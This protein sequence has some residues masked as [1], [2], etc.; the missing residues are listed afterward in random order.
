MSNETPVT[1]A[2]CIEHW[3]NEIKS[4]G[5]FDDLRQVMVATL[6]HLRA[7]A[8]KADVGVME[9][10]AAEALARPPVGV[11]DAIESG[12]RF[13]DECPLGETVSAAPG[14]AKC[15]TC[16]GAGRVMAN[17]F[18]ADR[19][20]VRAPKCTETISCP[21]CAP[22]PELLTFEFDRYRNGK[23]MAEG[24]VI[25]KA[26]NE[27]EAREIALRLYKGSRNDMGELRLREP[28]PEQQGAEQMP[29]L[30]RYYP[31]IEGIDDV[32]AAMV[33]D[34]TQGLWYSAGEADAH[35]ARLLKRI[36]RTPPA[37]ALGLSDDVINLA[38]RALQRDIN[39]AMEMATYWYQK[40]LFSSVEKGNAAN[41][42]AK[43]CEAACAS[44]RS[45]LER[46]GR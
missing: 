10:L 6:S 42:H 3:D 15:E 18:D 26:S 36:P 41:D 40:G 16:G 30:K 4:Y 1:L 17:L 21:D 31:Q 34:D 45:M 13:I 25:S 46:G 43:K 19:F 32:R 14:E 8:A 35:F 20:D 24:V 5:S 9:R 27:Q 22:S 2:E 7:S 11:T 29:K 33:W 44:L 37:P 12:A 28:S 23:L 39:F 38:I